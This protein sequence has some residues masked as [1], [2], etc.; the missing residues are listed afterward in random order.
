[1]NVSSQDL[2]HLK[3]LLLF[4]YLLAGITALFACLPIIHVRLGAIFL[5]PLGDHKP[6]F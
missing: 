6:Q 3:L 4:H 2:K 1:M 5:L